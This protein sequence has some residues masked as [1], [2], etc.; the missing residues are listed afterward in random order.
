MSAWEAGSFDNDDA[1]DWINEF[2]SAPSR[3]LIEST[4]TT[5]TDI[6]DDYLEAPESSMAI[7]AAEV[8]AALKNA[9]YPNLPEEIQDVLSNNE[10]TVDQSL[11]DLAIR[12]IERI[13]TNSELKE[14]WE[15][16]NASEWLTA[17][18]NLE[19]RLTR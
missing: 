7:A 2:S 12:A 16:S 9:P 4:L 3:D 14:L 1:L 13:K 15:E 17:I 19:E 5:V 11:V 18:N 6:G 10:I 8:V